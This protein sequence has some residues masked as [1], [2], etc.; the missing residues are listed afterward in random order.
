M[1]VMKDFYMEL[2]SLK[3]ENNALKQKNIALMKQVN[4]LKRLVEEVLNVDN[5]LRF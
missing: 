4:D 3:E 5:S 1:A 2:I